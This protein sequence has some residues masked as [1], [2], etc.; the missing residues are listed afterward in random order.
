MRNWEVFRAP[1][2][3]HAPRPGPA[4]RIRHYVVDGQAVVTGV[5][6]SSTTT[7]RQP[8]GP[9]ASVVTSQHLE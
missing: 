5:R 4:R 6:I 2:A 1:L 7:R 9:A 3:V 8:P